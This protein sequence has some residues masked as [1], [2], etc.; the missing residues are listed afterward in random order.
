MHNHMIFI[1]KAVGYTRLSTNLQAARD[2][3]L[4]RQAAHIRQSAS[5]Q[6]RNLL[7][8]YEEVGSAVGPDSLHARPQLQEALKLAAREGAFIVVTKPTR[9]FRNRQFGLKTL[10]NTGVRIYSLKDRCFLSRKKLGE[11]FYRGQQQAEVT[12]DATSK[13]LARAVRNLR[14]NSSAI[15]NS[16]NSRRKT[17]E[18]VAERIADILEEYPSFEKLTHR[19][20]SEMLNSRGVRSGWGRSWSAQSVR[21]R[22]KRAMEIVLERRALDDDNDVFDPMIAFGAE[23]SKGETLI[24][25]KGQKR[26]HLVKPVPNDQFDQIKSIP[27]DT[28]EAADALQTN[29]LFGLF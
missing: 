4:E 16:R 11:A 27:D 26:D 21:D 24:S 9:L 17:S 25:H 29:P 14:P 12:R 1:E 22:R 7:G 15:V 3:S 10:R 28:S 5:E 2:N 23:N 20:F 6:G 8:I 18:D 13:A 19:D